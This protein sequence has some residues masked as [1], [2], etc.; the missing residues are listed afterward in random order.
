MPSNI[1]AIGIQQACSPDK[2]VSL[3]TTQ[4]LIEKAAAQNADLIV[5]QELHATDYF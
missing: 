2:A 3:S 5:L 1:H 4:A